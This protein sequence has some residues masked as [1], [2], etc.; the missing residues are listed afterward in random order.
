VD[1]DWN[2][3]YLV[4]L[5]EGRRREVRCLEGEVLD[6][7]QNRIGVLEVLLWVPVLMGPGW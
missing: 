4:L 5:L 7:E 1:G 2:L 3:K 6:E